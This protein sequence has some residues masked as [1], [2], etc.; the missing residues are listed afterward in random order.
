MMNNSIILE[1]KDILNN[2]EQDLCKPTLLED[3]AR[4]N[5]IKRIEKEFQA[6]LGMS[7]NKYIFARRLCE[8]AKEIESG[9]IIDREFSE[10]Y[11]YTGEKSFYKAFA[12]FHGISVK[13][14]RNHIKPFR[15]F[16]PISFDVII[17]GGE[18]PEFK[19]VDI[20]GFTEELVVDVVNSDIDTKTLNN[21]RQEYIEEN[22]VKS[23]ALPSMVFRI[24]DGRNTILYYQKSYERNDKPKFHRSIPPMTCIVFSFTG[25]LLKTIDRNIEYLTTKWLKDRRYQI[26]DNCHF[27]IYKEGEI[28]DPMYQYDVMFILKINSLLDM[29]K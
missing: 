15:R 7:I 25:P 10:I 6:I 19:F 26:V 8:A 17:S 11:G 22:K 27:E 23:S 3:I 12:N 29:F 13:D 21:R 28:D 16:N 9:A 14:V 5:E 20:D 18:D 1:I 24:P 2:I 4:R